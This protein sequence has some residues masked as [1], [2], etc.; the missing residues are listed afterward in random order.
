MIQSISQ[1]TSLSRPQ[2]LTL[3]DI[4]YDNFAYYLKLQSEKL[5]AWCITNVLRTTHKIISKP[6]HYLYSIHATV[7][8]ELVNIKK[9]R[10]LIIANHRERIDAYLLLATLPY[11]VFEELLPIR[12]FTANVYLSHLW[13]R[14][15]FRLTGCFRAY[16]MEGKLSGL[17]GGLHL[18]DK[19]QSLLMFPQGRRMKQDTPKDVKIGPA[20]LALKRNFTI[21]PVH[22]T[23]KGSG[24]KSTQIIWGK[25][26][27]ISE[28]DN[29]DN[30]EELAVDIFKRVITLPKEKY[31]K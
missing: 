8:N 15:L 30:M 5:E 16:S 22:I 6:L 10:Y 14:V 1:V 17:K 24:R 29:K 9:G 2:Y 31:D 27:S 11:P 20:Y 18:S 4:I 7:P 3:L 12:M 21:L 26:C 13:Q 25:P 28:F 19:G 23:Y